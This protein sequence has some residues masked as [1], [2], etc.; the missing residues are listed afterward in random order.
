MSEGNGVPAARADAQCGSAVRMEIS[1]DMPRGTLTVII[2]R[3]NTGN[4]TW[5][6]DFDLVEG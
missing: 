4:S 3:D 2:F 6:A 5:T 1:I